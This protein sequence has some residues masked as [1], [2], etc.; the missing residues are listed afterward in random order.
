MEAPMMRKSFRYVP[1]A[2]ERRVTRR[3]TCGVLVVYGALALAIF[4]VAGL[5]HHLAGGS[6]DVASTAITAAA[7]GGRLSR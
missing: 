1:T 7:A 5:R 3:W 6:G 2:E 4:G